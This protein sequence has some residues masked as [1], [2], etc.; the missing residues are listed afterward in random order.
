MPNSHAT[1]QEAEDAY[2]DAI[3]ERDLEAMLS[4]WE[5]SEEIL[6]LLPMMPAQRGMAG[7]R[8]VW[9]PLFQGD[10][11]LEIEIRHLHWIETAD[12]AIHLVE[13]KVST[14][15]QPAA[16]VY[17]SN[18]Y[19]KGAQGWRL[20]MHQNSPTPPPPGLHVPG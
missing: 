19:R 11:A 12:L 6:C 4:V 13:E 17:A 14:S 1:P 15:A 18:I 8:S 10:I 16:P 20:L 7:V 9:E 5:E 2:Y 3:E